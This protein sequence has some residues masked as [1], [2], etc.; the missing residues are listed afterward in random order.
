MEFATNITPIWDAFW[1]ITANFAKAGIILALVA[2]AFSYLLLAVRRGP[3]AAGDA[4]FRTV[5][6]AVIDLLS[7]SP[8][9]VFALARLAVKES[10]R[11]RVIV[12]LAIFGLILLFAGWFLD[13][14]NFNPSEVYLSFVL[15]ATSY[16]MLLLA[17]FLSTYSLPADI[18]NRTIYTVVT[19]PVRAGEIVLGRI[20]GFMTI[21][22]VMLAIMGVAS[23]IFVIRALNHTHELDPV[24]VKPARVGQ[25]GR[26]N[27]SQNHS[28][29]VTLD[30]EGNGV[31]DFIRG[32]RHEIV[33][34][35]SDDGQLAYQVGPPV[36]MLVARVPVYGKLRFLDREGNA[37]DKGISVGQEWGYRSF[38]EG[39]SLAAAIWTFENLKTDSFPDGLPLEMSIRVFRSH[40]GDIEKGIAGGLRARNPQTGEM[41][42]SFN[43]LA[44]EFVT[45]QH[46]LPRKIKNTAGKTVD[47]YENFVVDGK[48]EIV[49]QCLL[50]AQY[51]GAAPADLYVQ[52][53]PAS[54]RFNYFKGYV[55]IWLQMLLVVSIGVM[56]STLVSGPV[57]MLATMGAI[58][59][60]FF[61][62]FVV[63]LA[64]SVL[65]GEKLV[66]GGGPLESLIRTATQANITTPLEDTP[67]NNAARFIDTI[68]MRAMRRVTELVPNF[69]DFKDTDYLALGYNIP[70]DQ[71]LAH[72]TYA[73]Y[74]MIL[75]FL[76]GYFFLRTR[77][78]AA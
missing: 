55:S 5:R 39:G 66:Y 49:L 15:T 53:P 46:F 4:V 10:I 44:K 56:F 19:K 77:E 71:L 14:Q 76:V 61:T 29:D 60:G 41:S 35:R 1:E 31:T 22:T 38:I 70:S 59:L 32:H 16:L 67:G 12:V 48:L 28:H 36:D 63:D 13:S 57:A 9:R 72:L 25:V 69:G 3:L 23:Y 24:Y 64:K 40:K 27:E 20:F 74:Y 42:E 26:T 68:L 34:K 7:I 11:R 33:G 18:K 47:L 37:K 8:R 73:L 62:G 78:L 45:D 65:D 21:G 2:L 51:F 75:T 58:I 54:F 17:L 52:S 6:T 30:D 50:P 43:F